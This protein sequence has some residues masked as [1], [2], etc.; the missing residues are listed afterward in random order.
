MAERST[1]FE[2]ERTSRSEIGWLV[3]IVGFALLVRF[4][5]LGHLSFSG[6]EETTALATLALLDGWPPSLP[7]GLS[8]VRSL[9]FTWLETVAVRI[10]G[11]EEAVFRSVPVL[12][13]AP[14]VLAMW[15]FARPILGPRPALAA[16][17]L[18]ALAPLDVEH[19]RTA[20]MYSLFSTLDLVFLGTVLRTCLGRGW[21]IR[22][23]LAGIGSAWVHMLTVFHA[24]VPLIAAIGA[25]LGRATRIRLALT[26]V[27]VF[28]GFSIV[29]AYEDGSY[30]FGLPVDAGPETP[31]PVEGFFGDLLRALQSGTALVVLVPA[32][33]L[34]LYCL[35]RA[36]RGLGGWLG[37]ALAVAAAAAAFVASPV[38]AF[39]ALA[40]VVIVERIDVAAWWSRLRWLL[41]CLIAGSG[42]WALALLVHHRDQGVGALRRT[43]ELLLGLP[44]PNWYDFALAAPL[45]FALAAVGGLLGVVEA[46]RSDRPAIWILLLAAAAMPFAA[47]GL[48]ERAEASRYH[49]HALAPLIV[50]ALFAVLRLSSRWVRS[51]L[52][53]CLIALALVGV[54]LRP[55]Q[56]YRTVFREHGPVSDPFSI[57]G[58]APDHR[59]AGRYL[60]SHAA[61][62]DWIV[63][64]DVL[65]MRYYAGRADFWLRGLHDAAA[66][67]RRDPAG[68]RPRDIY[69]G[70][71]LIPDIDELLELARAEP[72]RVLWVVTSGE[73]EVHP[74]WYRSDRTQSVLE[75]WRDR[76]WLEASDGL[77]RV[78]RLE[79][80]APV[81]PGAGD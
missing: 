34:G 5:R 51:D 22:P 29:R 1:G 47:S 10:A 23:I 16:A 77:T 50:L 59:S 6:D 27:L 48:F 42:G 26:G 33:A 19:S 61:D 58:V 57:V 11:L 63:A 30:A 69:T 65:Q 12:V 56:T 44:A 81:A 28:V 68:G 7:G 41:I 37:R 36:L 64:E 70:A 43:V 39:A 71:R 62:G 55:D 60:R 18:L 49:L 54:G 76:A 46:T 67:V 9:P 14:R 66:F 8:Y 21:T 13:A 53:A 15:W 38:L 78:Y 80:G 40:G 79:G 35:V 3:A 2:G 25:N 52:A 72:G 75:E 32:V 24:P 45:L 74:T 31:G 20:R 17:S 73:V 4:W